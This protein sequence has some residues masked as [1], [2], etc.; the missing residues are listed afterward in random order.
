MI[1]KALNLWQGFQYYG[2]GSIVTA[3]S[4]GRESI[5]GKIMHDAQVAACSDCLPGITEMA[6]KALSTLNVRRAEKLPRFTNS[7]T[8]LR[9][10]HGIIMKKVTEA[11]TG[12]MQWRL[13]QI[14]LLAVKRF[15]L[16]WRRSLWWATICHKGSVRKIWWHLIIKSLNHGQMHVLEYCRN[17]VGQYG[18]ILT[19]WPALNVNKM[20]I[21]SKYE[22]KCDGYILFWLY[23]TTRHICIFYSIAGRPW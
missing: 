19:R 3:F 11:K 1:S 17:M 4:Y 20:L 18:C 6:L 10:R 22:W 5:C 2:S 21:I 14:T 7:V 23:L 13:I 8:Y 16:R 9:K 15:E 12:N